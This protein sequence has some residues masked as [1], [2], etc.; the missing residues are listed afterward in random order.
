MRP[1]GSP[2]VQRFWMQ[3]TANGAAATFF[4]KRNLQTVLLELLVADSYEE[5][6]EGRDNNIAAYSLILQ[7]VTGSWARAWAV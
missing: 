1:T 6:K 3:S 4:A 5:R 2:Q 7:P